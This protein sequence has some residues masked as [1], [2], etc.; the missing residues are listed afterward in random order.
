MFRKLLTTRISIYIVLC[1]QIAPLLVF[2]STS[3]TAKSQEWWLPALLSC[4]VLVGLFQLLVRKTEKI[5]PWYLLS[6][7]QGFNIISRLMML[8]PHST[9]YVNKVQQFNTDYVTITVVSM[10]FSAFE[11]WYTEL[12]EVHNAILAD[13][14]KRTPA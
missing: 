6:F 4:F 1:L 12:T 10:L 3:Y 7:S 8:L 14:A 11:I 5:W 13:K 2:P 9:E